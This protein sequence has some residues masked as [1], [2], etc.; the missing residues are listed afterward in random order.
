MKPIKNIYTEVDFDQLSWHDNCIHGFKLE[1]EGERDE[2]LLD[3][4]FITEW[5]CDYGANAGFMLAPSTIAFRDIT[6]LTVSIVVPSSGYRVF[7][8]GI[9][10]DRIERSRLQGIAAEYYAW[11]IKVCAPYSGGFQFG[12][13]GFTMKLMAPP[14]FSKQQ[15]LGRSGAMQEP[16]DY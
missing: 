3:I 6:D 15:W 4:D 12:A 8:R 13:S 9:Y 1:S 14:V 2:I 16:G 7:H 11:D 5:I 10:I